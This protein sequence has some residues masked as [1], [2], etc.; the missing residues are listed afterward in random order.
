MEGEFNLSKYLEPESYERYRAVADYN[1]KKEVE[2]EQ[3]L[4]KVELI[5]LDLKLDS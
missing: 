2:L 5:L 1:D 3:Y 4:K